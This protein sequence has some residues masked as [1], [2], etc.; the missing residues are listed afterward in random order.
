MKTRSTVALSI[1]ASLPIWLVAGCQHTEKSS[2]PAGTAPVNTRTLGTIE[3]LDPR[4]DQLIPPGAVVEKLAEGFDWSEGPVWMKRDH[5][6]VFSDVPLNV[7]YRWKPGEGISIFLKPSGYT[8]SAVRGGE[9]GSNGLTVDAQGRLVLCEHGDRRVARL[10]TDGRKTTLA[11]RYDGKR[12]NSPNDLVFR[13]NGDL[14]FTDPPYGLQGLNDSPVKELPFNGVYRVTPDGVLRLLTKDLTFPNGI[15]FSPDEKT[16][17]VAVSDPKRAVV[18]A[19]E[20]QADGSIAQ[21]RVFFDATPLVGTR[22]GLPDGLKVDRRGNL[23]ATGPGGVLVLSPEG[24]HLGTIATG[25]ATANCA[26]G[27]DGSVLYITADMFLCRV[28]TSTRGF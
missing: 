3:R 5:C 24:K 13:S 6:L 9:P 17:Y 7:V 26:W 4:L 2:R 25:Q 27:E 19:Y 21:G 1:L 10:E 20:V 16:L 14:Y 18:M 22:A 11:D 12:L 23:F 8:G 28:R 15:A